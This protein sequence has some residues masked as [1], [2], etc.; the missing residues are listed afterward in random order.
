MF[1]TL[2]SIS[3]SLATKYVSLNNKLCMISPAFINLNPI[4]LNYYPF[5]I[6]LDKCNGSCNVVDDLS[7]KI[8]VPSEIKDVNVKVFNMIARIYKPKTLIKTCFM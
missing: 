4:E 8:S 1:V 6:M 3:G 5:M 7:T 2:F